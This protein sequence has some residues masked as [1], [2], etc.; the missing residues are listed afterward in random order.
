MNSFTT[1]LNAKRIARYLQVLI[2]LLGLTHLLSL[3]LSCLMAHP[4]TQ[5]IFQLFNLADREHN[6]PSLFFVGLLL[7]NAGLCLIIHRNSQTFRERGWAWPLLSGIFA[8]LAF[9][10][11]SAPSHTTFYTLKTLFQGVWF[12][13]SAIVLLAIGVIVVPLLFKLRI[14]IRKWLLLAIVLYFAGAIGG[15]MIG[16]GWPI[17]DRP[18]SF[19]YGLV[20][21]NQ[22]M[23]EMAGLAT[24]A[25]ALLRLIEQQY[26]GFILNIPQHNPIG[27]YYTTDNANFG[28]Q[29]GPMPDRSLLNVNRSGY[30]EN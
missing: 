11:F 22:K 8:F 2:A 18:T 15:E 27:Y 17:S 10:E 19:L 14:N 13:P 12:I 5:Y 30:T 6:L 29:A 7:L 20:V 4:T 9:D 1:T 25:Y 26:G 28:I 23:V 21:C 24:L 3:S 16:A